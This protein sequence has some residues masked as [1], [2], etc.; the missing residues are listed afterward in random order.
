MADLNSKYDNLKKEYDKFYNDPGTATE[1][2]IAEGKTAWV[3]G[4]KIT[5]TLE[6]QSNVVVVA[7]GVSSYNA[8]YT[9]KGKTLTKDNFYFVVTSA[10]ALPKYCGRYNSGTYTCTINP[11]VS[12]TNNVLILSG[13]TGS[14]WPDPNNNTGIENLTITGNIYCIY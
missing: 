4:N 2:D 10:Y 5:G 7:T 8:E 12:Y 1:S 3:N 6:T 14:R 13:C 11:S 9:I